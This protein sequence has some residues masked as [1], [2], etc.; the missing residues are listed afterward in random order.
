MTDTSPRQAE[1]PVDSLFLNRWSPRAFTGEAVPEKDVLTILDAARWAPSAF[2]SQPWR[3][4]YAV[5]GTE[6]FDR[7]LGLLNDFNRSWAKEAGAIVILLSKTHLLPPG[8]A[9]EV[10]SYSHTLDA[11]AAWGSAALQATLLGYSVHGMTGIHLDK[12]AE[13]LGVPEGYRPELAFAIG[14]RGDKS[15]LP[16]GLAAREAPSPRKPLAEIAFEGSFKG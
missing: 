11:G 10:P 8:A 7:L 3:F 12:V 9:E 2:N 16:E 15:S 13:T 5:K 4:V 6:N 1:F 14:K